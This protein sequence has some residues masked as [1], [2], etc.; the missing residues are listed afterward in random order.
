MAIRCCH[1]PPHTCKRVNAHTHIWYWFQVHTPRKLPHA[2]TFSSSIL[3][4]TCK[5][6]H[7][8]CSSFHETD[9]ASYQPNTV[10]CH[11]SASIQHLLHTVTVKI[12]A[13]RSSLLIP[14]PLF[15]QN[16]REKERKKPNFSFTGIT[17]ANQRIRAEQ[18]NLKVL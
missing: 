9:S 12:N 5:H 13:E 6:R 2:F 8:G 1:T 10:P 18:V 15:L 4:H 16:Q 11:G 14:L 7:Q 3:A 17:R